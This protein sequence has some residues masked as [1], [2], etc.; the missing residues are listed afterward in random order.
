M[1]WAGKV[2]STLSALC[3][4]WKD[5]GEKDRRPRKRA[6]L[7]LGANHKKKQSHATSGKRDKERQEFE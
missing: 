2:G 3:M 4:K 5:K 1:L 7:K 6:P